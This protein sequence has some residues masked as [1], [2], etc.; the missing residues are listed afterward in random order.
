MFSQIRIA[1]IWVLALTLS[2]VHA[3]PAPLAERALSYLTSAQIN[4][5][6][7]YT[8]FASASYCSPSLTA[9]W[10][11][12]PACSK[13]SDFKA[14]DSG[15]DGAVVQYWFVGY[16]PPMSSIVVVYQGTDPF[17]LVPLLQDAN[18]FL[19]TPPQSLFPGLPSGA[20]VHNGFLQAFTYS[21]NSVFQAVQQASTTYNTKKITLIGH[22]MGAAIA[23]IAASSLKLRLGSAYTFKVV[24]Y[25]KPRVG[26][27]A[28][29][30][31]VNSNVPDK[32]RINNKD[33]PVPIL[34]GRFMG[35]AGD[36][37]EIHIRDD[38]AWVVCPGNDN[39]EA[40][41]TVTDVGNILISNVAQ[42]LG[43]YNGILMGLCGL[44]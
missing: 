24:G 6:D 30:N 10:N 26:N 13:L 17:K 25:G 16:Y 2:I 22:S 42:H 19:T 8:L 1:L 40:G 35:F 37:G 36:E 9:K 14:V 21:Q 27:P 11:C 31:W 33:D 44:S 23:T 38:N 29:S 3:A 34:P 12:G 20:Q 7:P 32:K 5:F 15:G 28:W 4:A 18:F 43:P 39:T 41:C